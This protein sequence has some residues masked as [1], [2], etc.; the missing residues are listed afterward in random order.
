MGHKKA[1]INGGVPSLW[2]VF[3]ENKVE[4][5]TLVNTKGCRASILFSFFWQQQH[6][7]MKNLLTRYHTFLGCD[8]VFLAQ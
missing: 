3:K 5:I 1:S 2:D 8:Q 4:A 6:G 7:T